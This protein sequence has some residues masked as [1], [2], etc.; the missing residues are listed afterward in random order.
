MGAPGCQAP[1]PKL[2][3]RDVSDLQHIANLPVRYHLPPL[4]CNIDSYFE[5]PPETTFRALNA[6]RGDLSVARVLDKTPRWV[7]VG[8]QQDWSLK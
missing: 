1:P 7:K 2:L 4:P 6:N 5:L 8:G 3:F